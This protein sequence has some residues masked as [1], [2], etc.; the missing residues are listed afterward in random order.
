MSFLRQILETLKLELGFIKVHT[1]TLSLA[2]TD[3][4][5]KE[6]TA[7]QP[8]ILSERLECQLKGVP[9][10]TSVK[11]SSHLIEAS[12]VKVKDQTLGKIEPLTEDVRFERVSSEVHSCQLKLGAK[13]EKI[14]PRFQLQIGEASFKINVRSRNVPLLR[15]IRFKPSNMDEE[16]KRRVLQIIRVFLSQRKAGSFKFIG[17]YRNVPV[18][19]VKR[20]I[21]LDREL[22]IELKEDAKGSKKDLIVLLVDDCYVFLSIS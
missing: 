1:P 15:T 10:H 11:I 16:Q 19:S 21:V 17:F 8:R 5:V 14:Q 2:D 6:E 22:T 4:V 9:L 12:C 20:M 18:D 13:V 7:I 3:I